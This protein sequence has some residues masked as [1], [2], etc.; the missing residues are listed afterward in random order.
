MLVSASRTSLIVAAQPSHTRAIVTLHYMELSQ[1]FFSASAFRFSLREH[2]CCTSNVDF[3]FPDGDRPSPKDGLQQYT[4]VLQQYRVRKI[5]PLLHHISY[6]TAAI[7][8]RLMH[9]QDACEVAQ[10]SYPPTC[11][12]SIWINVYVGS[13][14]GGW[15]SLS[16]SPKEKPCHLPCGDDAKLIIH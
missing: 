16:P 4:A 9:P 14:G 6:C 7:A 13:Y 15:W 11:H 3:R 1:L 10:H 12:Q 5:Q 2:T 8:V